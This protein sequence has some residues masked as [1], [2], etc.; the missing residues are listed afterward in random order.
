LKLFWHSPVKANKNIIPLVLKIRKLPNGCIGQ[1]PNFKFT[2]R[3]VRYKKGE[4]K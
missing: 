4:Y 2:E 1:N 3:A